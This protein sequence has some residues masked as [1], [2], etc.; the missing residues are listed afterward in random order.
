L[1]VVENVTL[2]VDIDRVY[3]NR[4]VELAEKGK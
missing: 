2:D 4:F 3:T 1:R